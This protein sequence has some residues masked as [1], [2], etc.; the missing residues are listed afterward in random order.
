MG[1]VSVVGQKEEA[2]GIVIQAAHGKKTGTS[3][4]HQTQDGR[5]PLRVLYRSDRVFGLVKKK[6]DF[7]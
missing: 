3:F 6:V 4:F 7:R 1:Q 2:F 5:P